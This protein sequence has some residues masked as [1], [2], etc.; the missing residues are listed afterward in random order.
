MGSTVQLNVKGKRRL[1]V[2]LFLMLVEFVAGHI[3]FAVALPSAASIGWLAIYVSNVF[4]NI[5]H[6]HGWLSSSSAVALGSAAVLAPHLWIGNDEAALRGVVALASAFYFLRL[7]ACCDSPIF[8]DDEK[9]GDDSEQE[10][11]SQ[12]HWLERVAHV[13]MSFHDIRK[14]MEP[15]PRW[16]RSFRCLVLIAL[17]AAIMIAGQNVRFVTQRC[18]HDNSNTSCTCF[19]FQSNGNALQILNRSTSVWYAG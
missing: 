10:P 7:V 19:F 11:V 3:A 16:T 8:G 13:Q 18:S 12:L 17:D 2:G 15:V 4:L 1:S 6:Y 5:A 9:D 14:C